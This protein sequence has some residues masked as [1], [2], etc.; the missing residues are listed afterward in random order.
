MPTIASM[1]ILGALTQTT[2][3]APER[4]AKHWR[5]PSPSLV[6][7]SRFAARP[8]GQTAHHGQQAEQPAALHRAATAAAGRWRHHHRHGGDVQRLSAAVAGPGV[9][10]D[11]E[12]DHHRAHPAGGQ[13]GRAAVGSGRQSGQGR[14]AG[15]GPAVAAERAAKGG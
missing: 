9:V 13:R 3:L 5:I 10:G 15:D 11:D 14:A 8:A 1:R 2:L 12:G 6:S 4:R 7:P